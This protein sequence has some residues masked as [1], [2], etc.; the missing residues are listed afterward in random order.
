VA[1]AY[2]CVTDSGIRL[3]LLRLSRTVT[4]DK[5]C[6]KFI[7]RALPVFGTTPVLCTGRGGGYSTILPTRRRRDPIG[8]AANS[9][10]LL[11]P[12][13]RPSAPSF[14]LVRASRAD[15]NRRPTRRAGAVEDETHRQA[16]ATTPRSMFLATKAT[17]ARSQGTAAC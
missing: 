4:R 5:N 10:G 13:L 8:V 11:T 16:T 9:H 14:L 7:R 1:T 2:R 12:V 15:V 6:H 3:T 17:T